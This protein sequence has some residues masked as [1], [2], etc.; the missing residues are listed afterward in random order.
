MVINIPEKIDHYFSKN[1]S[2]EYK[3]YK[4]HAI[5]RNR[6]FNFFTAKGVFSPKNVDLGTKIL[7][8]KMEIP[9]NDKGGLI[10]DMGCGYG[11]VGIVASTINPNLTIHFIDINTRSAELSKKKR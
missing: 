11:V 2:S 6:E 7:C 1:P 4:I 10:L 8:K 3:E 9:E 5:L